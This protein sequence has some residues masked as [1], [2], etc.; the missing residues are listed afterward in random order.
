MEQVIT[1]RLNIAKPPFQL[2][3]GDAGG[4]ALFPQAHHAPEA[5]GSLSF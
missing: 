5:I 3:A 2:H 4:H 1:I